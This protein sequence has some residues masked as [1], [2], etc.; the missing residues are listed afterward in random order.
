MPV[1]FY[2]DPD[3]VNDAEAGGIRN[4]TLSYTFHQTEMPEEQASLATAP[5]TDLN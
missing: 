2:V 5:R 1:T 4:I 3:I